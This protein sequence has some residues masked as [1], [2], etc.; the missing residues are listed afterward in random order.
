MNRTKCI[1]VPLLALGLAGVLFWV[2]HNPGPVARESPAAPQQEKRHS[3]ERA[4]KVPVRAPEPKNIVRGALSAVDPE[5]FMLPPLS[6]FENRCSTNELMAV[7]PLWMQ[8]EADVDAYA[9]ERVVAGV[10]VT[11]VRG[12][13][14]WPNGSL[15]EVEISDLGED[16]TDLL[17]RSVG[18]NTAL[19]NIVTEAGFKL[20]NNET[21]SPTNFEY[22]YQNGA[23]SLQVLVADRFLVEVQL[24]LLLPESFEAVIEHQVPMAKL[25]EIAARVR[26]DSAE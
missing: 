15:M 24:E 8:E 16:P 3:F 7:L 11:R 4:G 13:Y 14:S 18:Y 10:P 9:D 22:D 17:L 2:L 20:R 26:K 12:R 19:S 23:G 25:E 6:P 5:P 21:S 1:G